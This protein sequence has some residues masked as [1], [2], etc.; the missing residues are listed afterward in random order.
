MTDPPLFIRYFRPMFFF[1]SSLFLRLASTFAINISPFLANLSVQYR[2]LCKRL[3]LLLFIISVLSICVF[4][5]FEYRV[6]GFWALFR[7]PRIMHFPST[8]FALSET[9]KT[10]SVTFSENFF[11]RRKIEC[12][13]PLTAGHYVNSNNQVWKNVAFESWK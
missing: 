6:L 10:L 12:Q 3:E 4:T 11:P 7:K 2:R 9:N 13:Q 5:F 1:E 8:P